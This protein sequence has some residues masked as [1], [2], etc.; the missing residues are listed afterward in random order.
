MADVFM[1]LMALPNIIGIFLLTKDSVHILKDYDK[2]MA[3]KK[4][5]HWEYEY[6]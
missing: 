3:S 4:D 5:L 6:D 2:Q 1:G